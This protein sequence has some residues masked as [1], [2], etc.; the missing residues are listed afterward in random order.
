MWFQDEAGI[1][2]KNTLTRV[3]GQTGGRTRG[4]KVRGF[5]SAY[6]FGAGCPGEWEIGRVH[7]PMP[8]RSHPMG[9]LPACAM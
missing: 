1:G 3:W 4:R 6:V 2:Q 8:T 9:L 7:M 5:I